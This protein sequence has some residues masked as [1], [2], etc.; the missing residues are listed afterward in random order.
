[1]MRIIN[2]HMFINTMENYSDIKE[3]LISEIYESPGTRSKSITKTDYFSQ[4]G[5][6]NEKYWHTIFPFI[7][8]SYDRIRSYIYGDFK[9]SIDVEFHNV[10]HHIYE[11]NSHHPYHA[12]PACHFSNVFY[13]NLPSESVITHYL[14]INDIKVK[15]GDMITFPGWYVHSSPK[16]LNKES[17]MVIAFNTSFNAMYIK[18]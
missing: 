6:S 14:N 2:D 16:N 1:M 18:Q 11:E 10:W 5:G 8:D 9:K 17:K 13:V 12:H 3:R 15:E 4:L 7:E